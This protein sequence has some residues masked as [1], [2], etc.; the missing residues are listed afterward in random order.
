MRITAAAAPR[1]ASAADGR[2]P[3][4]DAKAYQLVL[5]PFLPAVA[6]GLQDLLYTMSR[7][8]VALVTAR[9]TDLRPWPAG[10]PLSDGLPEP[11]SDGTNTLWVRL[12]SMVRVEEFAEG[13]LTKETLNEDDVEWLEKAFMESK[14]ELPMLE[15]DVLVEMAVGA[16]DG[17]GKPLF[18]QVRRAAEKAVI[19]SHESQAALSNNLH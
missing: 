19:A 5:G 2:K 10:G 9:P 11:S 15:E 8:E 6:Q 3:P 4:K 17:E 14:G 1:S 12:D 18:G 13:K 16:A 7:E